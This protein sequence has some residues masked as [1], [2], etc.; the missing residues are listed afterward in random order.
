MGRGVAG[1]VRLTLWAAPII[2]EHN[3]NI[4]NDNGEISRKLAVLRGALASHGLERPAAERIAPLGH[5]GADACLNGGLARGALH[6]VFA[7]APGQEAAASGFALALAVRVLTKHKWLLWIR[8][9]F[10]ALESGEIY[11]AGLRELGLDPSR[12]LMLH[13]PDAEAVLRAAGDA[14]DCKGLGAVVIEPWGEPKIFDLVASRRLTL[15]AAKHNVTAILLRPGAEPS[16]SAAETRWLVRAAPSP[17]D[18]DWGA[19]LFDVSL[20]R[21]RHGPL[22]HWVMEWDQDESIFRTAHHGALAA[23]I[24]DRPAE[25]ALECHR[26]AG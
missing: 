1:S 24:A 12:A 10:S 23:A 20:A 9:D 2:L 14:L 26:Q 25:A 21:N 15:A 11:G 18:D 8:Q 22:G 6:E 4:W 7:G 16:P 5:P 17:P 13:A 19:P 3:M